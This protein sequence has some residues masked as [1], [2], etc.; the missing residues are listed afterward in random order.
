MHHLHLRQD[1]DRTALA[2]ITSLLDVTTGIEG[3][4]PIGEHKMAHLR[5]GASDWDGILA[6]TDDHRL[7]GYA[8]LRWNPIGRDPRVAVEVVVHPHHR[9]QGIQASLLDATRSTVARAGG[10]RMFL[11]VHRVEDP[12]DTLAAGMGFAIQ[13]ELA[14]MR[15]PATPIPPP[16]SGPEGV[17]VRPYRGRRDEAA[18]LEVNNAAFEGHPENGGW[19]HDEFASRRD[20]P[21]FDPDGLFMAFRRTADGGEGEPLG[22]HWTKWHTH[23]AEDHRPHGPLGE[24]YVL[25]V[26]PRGRGIGLGRH[27]L[28]VGMRHLATRSE[29]IVLYVDRAEEGPVALYTSEGFEVVYSEVC[30]VD[31]VASA[32]TGG[33]TLLRPAD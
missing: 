2:E 30:Y 16:R 26:H 19:D 22:F 25:A 31:D 4:A 10:G 33:R 11:W 12:H 6:Y 17:L 24:V 23:D 29:S 3:H 21:W 28:R 5:V 13:R 20:L 18:F 1:L 27:L 8:H 9:D 32:A 14:F 15:R 7:I